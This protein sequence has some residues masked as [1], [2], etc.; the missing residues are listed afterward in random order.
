MSV[1]TLISA[2]KEARC[3]TPDSPEGARQAP[4]SPAQSTL[5]SNGPPSPVNGG[6]NDS[7]TPP[8]SAST[9][10]S[11]NL[12]NVQSQ[13]TTLGSLPSNLT[14]QLVKVK[15]FLSTLVQFGNDIGADV[16][17]RVK[18][19][20]LN[21]VSS[22]LS[23]EEFHH[24]LQDV[25]NFPLRP[26]V[27]PFLRTHLPLLQREAQALAR[28]NKQSTLQYVR[29]HEHAVLDA[30]HSPSELSDIF[31][32]N[33]VNIAGVKRRA[34][35]SYENGY[36]IHHVEDYPPNK[37]PL[38]QN[39]FYFAHHN[40]ILP[41]VQTSLSHPHLLD[42]ST[43]T[44]PNKIEDSNNNNNR[45][46]EE[47]K[48]IYVMLNCIL[49]MVE[50]TKR[51]LTI[52]QQRNN[53]DVTNDWFRKQDVSIDL[54]K[55]ANEIMMQAVKQ[56]EE[57]VAEVKKRAED[58]VNDVK[59][60]AVIDLQKAVAV[61]EAKANEL[62]AVERAK[63][64]KLLSDSKKSIDENTK[65][66]L[67][68]PENSLSPPVLTQPAPSQQNACWNCGRKAHETCSGCGIARYCGSFCQHKDWENHHQV[69]SKEKTLARTSSI[70]A[71]TPNA[72]ISTTNHV[73]QL[74]SPPK[75]N[76]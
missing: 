62:I 53:Q 12:E 54:K 23:I 30:A 76:K 13:H 40:M 19:L 47:W 69:C 27:L 24:S 65:P 1:Q 28:A 74:E 3:K 48:N 9:A 15:R 44:I 11:V 49:S 75:F 41:H 46:E 17:E 8:L 2:N 32:P 55:A 33:E 66:H 22:N 37:K 36:S 60:Q 20:V 52:L 71:T 31:M 35:E 57:R 59:R 14:R 61:A 16:G 18:S 38:T 51:A 5:P 7:S 29:N 73:T 42:Y 50:K 25:T 4:R 68:N 39:P 6:S 10:I 63:M 72:I 58:A 43:Q 56:T 45:G 34:S 70:R 67:E 64:E 26:F 21:L